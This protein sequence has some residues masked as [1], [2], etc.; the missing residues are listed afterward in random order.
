[1]PALD[2][3]RYGFDIDPSLLRED[4]I[5]E[6][7]PPLSTGGASSEALNTR[8]ILDFPDGEA[9]DKSIEDISKWLAQVYCGGVGYEV[10][11]M[12]HEDVERSLTS[13]SFAASS[14]TCLP[15]TNGASSNAC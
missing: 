4:F 3:R 12:G 10:G 7:L 6:T 5:S 9:P 8:G 11:F 15:S 1:M 2:P 14:R 13:L